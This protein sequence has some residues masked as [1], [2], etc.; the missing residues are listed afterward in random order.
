MEKIFLRRLKFIETL[1]FKGRKITKIDSLN[2]NL[3]KHKKDYS[4]DFIHFDIDKIHYQFLA[5][6]VEL[7]RYYYYHNFYIYN[8]V[9]F[10]KI[11][12]IK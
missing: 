6:S 2:L 4:I 5:P 10:D 1:I 11:P 8:V 7:E 12:G 3:A 9:D